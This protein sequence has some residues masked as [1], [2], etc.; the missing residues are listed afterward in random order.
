VVVS[1]IQIVWAVEVVMDVVNGRKVRSRLRTTKIYHVWLPLSGRK[2]HTEGGT[3]K[4]TAGGFWI[5]EMHH[6]KS[7]VVDLTYPWWES[8]I[9]KKSEA[10]M[11]RNK[12]HK[13][14]QKGTKMSSSTSWCHFYHTIGTFPVFICIGKWHEKHIYYSVRALSINTGRTMV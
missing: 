14:F 5:L 4:G 1:G 6:L 2:V 13:D 7:T 3:N 9:V 12:R 11:A 10:E 8:S